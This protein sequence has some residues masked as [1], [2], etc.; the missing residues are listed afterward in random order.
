VDAGRTWGGDSEMTDVAVGWGCGLD[1]R[2]ALG[3]LRLDWG[4]GPDTNGVFYFGMGESF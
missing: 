4:F 2:M 1:V 3:V